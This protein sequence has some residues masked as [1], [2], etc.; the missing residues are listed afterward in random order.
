MSGYL[1]TGIKQ[2]KVTLD[3]ASVGVANQMNGYSADNL[4]L[5]LTDEPLLETNLV[6]N[7]DGEVPER[8]LPGWPI[9]RPRF[10]K[11]VPG[12]N[13][14]PAFGADPSDQWLKPAD[15]G[16]PVEARGKYVLTIDNPRATFTAF[17]T[18]DLPVPSSR[19]D[20]AAYPKSKLSQM[21]DTG[22]VTYELRGWLGHYNGGRDLINLRV[23]FFDG[24][25]TDPITPP[26][27]TGVVR[28]SDH[29]D[30][31][32]LAER[33]VNG[34]VPAGTR[35][36]L[37]ELLGTKAVD[38]GVQMLLAADNLSLVLRAPESLK[39]AS[40]SNSASGVAGMA[41]APG[42]MVTVAISGTEITGVA[43][44]QLA[45]RV[46]PIATNL[47]GATVTFDGVT[48]PLL[49]VGAGKIGTVV[50]YEVFGKEKVP[51][52]VSYKGEKTPALAVDLAPAV[53]GIFTQ[54]APG[55]GS[56][57]ALVWNS[58]LRMNSGANPAAKGS[59][60]TIFWTGGGQTDPAGRTGMV[61][62]GTLPR[63]LL[64]VSATIDGQTATVQYAGGV[65]GAWAGLLMAQVQ[66][67]E[68]VNSGSV[69]VVVTV[70]DA[71]KGEFSSPAG[72]ATVS[73]Q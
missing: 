39:I 48:A 33:V 9:V 32:G 65:Y 43:G 37:V 14:H 50:P 58:D 15:P 67:P 12:W 54:E 60:V 64:P 18:I 20:P 27:E 21:L 53:P 73:I 38:M 19:L 34:S 46:G 16:P 30:K 36:I 8:P 55:A 29:E 13:Q 66:V 47:N 70:T 49:Y 17:Q 35:R 22:K 72:A 6:L 11:P 10:G 44:M 61:E 40:I 31:N 42:E 7:G 41:V 26:G 28:R 57:A 24:V 4:S 51:V 68:G 5:V 3:L 52:V 2:A 63:P 23:S 69:P 62:W 71:A 56:T 25:K 59:I 1:N 45:D